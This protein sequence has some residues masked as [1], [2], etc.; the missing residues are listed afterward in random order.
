VF[1]SVSVR[2]PSL[3]PTDVCS[4]RRLSTSAI[5]AHLCL[6]YTVNS[7]FVLPPVRSCVAVSSCYGRPNFAVAGPTADSLYD[8]TQDVVLRKQRRL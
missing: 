7:T 8:E 4:R 6:I 2:F 3:L 5:T 1:G